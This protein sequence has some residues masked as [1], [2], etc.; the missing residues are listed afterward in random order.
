MWDTAGQ[1]EFHVIHAMLLGTSKGVFIVVYDC[2]HPEGEQMQQV[3]SQQCRIRI[4]IVV[5][6]SV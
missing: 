4:G 3:T 6:V 5:C 1:V 2:R